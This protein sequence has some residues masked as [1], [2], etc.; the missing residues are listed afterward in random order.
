[1]SGA[2][3]Q[4]PGIRNQGSGIRDQ[5][6][7]IRNQEIGDQ[8]FDPRYLMPDARCRI[9]G[10]VPRGSAPSGLTLKSLHWSDFTCLMTEWPAGMVPRGSPRAVRTACGSAPSGLTLKSLHWSDFA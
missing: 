8:L 2:R 4:E 9:A 7:G 6:T 10:L 1:M 5:Q 3:D